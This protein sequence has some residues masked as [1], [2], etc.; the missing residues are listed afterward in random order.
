MTFCEKVCW[1]INSET[2]LYLINVAFGR[3]N[4]AFGSVTSFL[5]NWSVSGLNGFNVFLETDSTIL[6]QNNFFRI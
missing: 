6:H 2:G 1:Q 4:V 3:I 5:Q